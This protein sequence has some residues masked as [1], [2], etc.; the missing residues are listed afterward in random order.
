MVF[1]PFMTINWRKNPDRAVTGWAGT[2]IEC[3]KI[4]EQINKNIWKQDSCRDSGWHC[5]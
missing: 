5:K 1:L 3:N 4:F 2:R